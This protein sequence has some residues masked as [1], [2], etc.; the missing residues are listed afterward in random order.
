MKGLI[1]NTTT[2]PEFQYLDGDEIKTLPI[3]NLKFGS[4]KVFNIG[5]EVEFE[6]VDEFSHP[7]LFD[8]VPWGEGYKCAKIK[9]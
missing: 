6:I 5:S 7:V 2:G 3:Y 9:S 1:T 4:E 8:N